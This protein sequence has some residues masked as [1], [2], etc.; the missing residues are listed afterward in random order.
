MTVFDPGESA[1]LRSRPRRDA[2]TVSAG[3]SAGAAAVVVAAVVAVVVAAVLIATRTGSRA[4]RGVVEVAAGRRLGVERGDVRAVEVRA[5]L[6]ARCDSFETRS[7]DA[8][9]LVR[10]PAVGGVV[11]VFAGSD[12]VA[13]SFELWPRCGGCAYTV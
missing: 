1:R 13:E 11:G 7:A 3:V 2:G 5:A 10:S 6:D 12:S 9:S 4:A 8:A